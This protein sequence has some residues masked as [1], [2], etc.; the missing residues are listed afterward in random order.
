M[1]H[2]KK[3]QYKENESNKSHYKDKMNR[4]NKLHLLL[5]SNRLF[6][7]I[8]YQCLMLLMRNRK[9]D[10]YNLDNL[11]R[12]PYLQYYHKC[13][14]CLCY[15]LLK[16]YYQLLL[17]EYIHFLKKTLN[18]RSLRL[19]MFGYRC[20]YSYLDIW[21]DHRFFFLSMSYNNNAHLK[22]STR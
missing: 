10:L 1:P 5:L 14:Y 11:V 13:I 19:T 18:Y 21:F 9:N 22:E 16:N 20:I 3:C 6:C 17:F 8:L 4:C 7:S 2:S 12:K 15:R